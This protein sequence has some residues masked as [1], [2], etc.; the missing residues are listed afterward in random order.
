MKVY[1]E[2]AMLV[3]DFENG[4]TVKYD[5]ES[6]V[7][8]GLKGKPVQSLNHQ[9]RGLSMYNIIM[10]CVDK[11]YADFLRLVNN[12]CPTLDNV[13]SILACAWKYKNLEQ[14]CSAGLGKN[15]ISS[16]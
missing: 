13:G 8:I 1:K 16:F 5:L 9:L 3:F 15:I 12:A 6:H 7:T 11:N 14:I 10:S 2:N 4:K